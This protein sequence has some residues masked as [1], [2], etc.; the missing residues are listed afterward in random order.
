M[1]TS[2]FFSISSRV[3]YGEVGCETLEWIK[4][5]WNT[6]WACALQAYWSRGRRLGE[7]D[8]TCGYW[9]IVFKLRM[10]KWCSSLCHVETSVYELLRDMLKCYSTNTPG[11]VSRE[12]RNVVL[13]TPIM[14]I[15]FIL[16]FCYTMPNTSLPRDEKERRVHKEENCITRPLS[17]MFCQKRSWTSFHLSLYKVA[18]T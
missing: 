18:D 10:L 13:S 11:K 3:E 8:R 17:L 14:A 6:R 16:D 15:F 4:R 1:V 5:K 7:R 2:I 9:T 12:K